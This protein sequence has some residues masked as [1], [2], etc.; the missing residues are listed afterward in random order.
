VFSKNSVVSHI[1]AQDQ[2]ADALIEPLSAAKFCSLHD[3]LL[4]FDKHNLVVKTPSTSK[5]ECYRVIQLA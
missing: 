1:P 3:K 4:V 5:G 2:W